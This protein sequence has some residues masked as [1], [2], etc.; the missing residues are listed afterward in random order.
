MRIV[1]VRAEPV[2]RVL[3]IAYAVLGLSAFLTYAISG[4]ETFTLPFG[5]LAPLFH[6]NLNV[7]LARSSGVL[8]NIFLCVA[9]LLSYAVTGWI[10]GAA[11]AVCFNVV[12][13]YTGGVD[14]KYF[15]VASKDVPTVVDR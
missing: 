10:T 2:A 14:A 3:A 8:Y 11:A 6:L 7:N 15:S 4:A 13:R 12:A 9:G 1:S 5:V